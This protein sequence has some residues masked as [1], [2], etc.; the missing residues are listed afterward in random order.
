M[1]RQKESVFGVVRKRRI[2]FLFLVCILNK[3]EKNAK[4]IQ[5]AIAFSIFVW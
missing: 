1:A 2:L 4:K 3:S 5:K